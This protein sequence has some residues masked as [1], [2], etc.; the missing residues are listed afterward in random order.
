ME[1]TSCPG[2]GDVAEI[3]ARDVLASTSGPVEHVSTRCVHRHVFSLP[4]EYLHR[5]PVLPAL[6]AAPR[7]VVQD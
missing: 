4:V 6:P 1:L 3:V 2:C 7:G 5:S